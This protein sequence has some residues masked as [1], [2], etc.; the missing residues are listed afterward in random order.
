MP[1]SKNQALVDESIGHAIDL[2]YYANGVVREE[3]GGLNADDDELFALLLAALLALSPGATPAQIDAAIGPALMLSERAYGDVSRELAAKMEELAREEADYQ[4]ELL[5]A[6]QDVTPTP[7]DTNGTIAEMLAV[8]ILGLTIAETMRGLSAARSDAIR[9]AAQAGFVNGQT[10]D[11][12][13]RAL[14]GTKSTGFTDGTFNK[15][16]HH[17]ETTIRT[18]LSHATSYVTA[19]VRALNSNIV[20]AVMWVSVLDSATSSWCIAR[21]GK[22]YTADNAHRPIG[23]SYDWGAGPGRYHYNCRSTSAP[24]LAGEVPNANAFGDWLGRQSAARQDE[25]LGPTRGALY[26]RGQ[27]SVEGFLNNKGKLLTLAQLQA[28]NAGIP[29][30]A[31]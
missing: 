29:A 4:Q 28:R 23:H 16:R 18:A 10:P 17:L 30:L 3:V 25:V 19:A 20:R 5:A 7:M 31:A 11:E 15:L 1:I 14:R 2:Q 22:R 12:I 13:V 24:L 27:V 9:R 26:R 8:P 21:A 6:A